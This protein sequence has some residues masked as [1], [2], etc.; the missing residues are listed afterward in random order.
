MKFA[1]G[2]MVEAAEAGSSSRGIHPD[3][4]GG[5][6]IVDEC[7]MSSTVAVASPTGG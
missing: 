4:V 6:D 2:S 7:S 1:N 3:I 5:D